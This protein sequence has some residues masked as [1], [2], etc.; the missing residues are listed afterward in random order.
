M[1][2]S[3][4][5]VCFNSADTIEHTIRSVREQSCNELLAKSHL[6]QDQSP[7]NAVSQKRESEGGIALSSCPENAALYVLPV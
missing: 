6:M 1:K 5:T 2:V 3:V 7:L 4:V